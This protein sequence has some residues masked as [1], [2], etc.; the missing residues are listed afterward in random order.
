MQAVVE[1][2]VAKKYARL[3]WKKRM[4]ESIGKNIDLEAHDLKILESDSNEI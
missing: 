4:L 1:T 2:R 3:R